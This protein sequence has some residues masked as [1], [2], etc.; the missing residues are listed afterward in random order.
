MLTR[1]EVIVLTFDKQTYTDAAETSNALGYATTLGKHLT[2]CT[3]PS[4]L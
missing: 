4:A 1:S 2:L 3:S